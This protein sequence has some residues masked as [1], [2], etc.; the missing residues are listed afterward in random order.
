MLLWC[1]CPDP[2]AAL[3]VHPQ[4]H[5]T[6]A[7]LAP[8]CTPAPSS[9]SLLLLPRSSELTCTNPAEPV[10]VYA[11]ADHGVLT[12]PIVAPATKLVTVGVCE[13]SVTK[14]APQDIT[15]TAVLKGSNQVV[16]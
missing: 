14:V 11:G 12:L 15:D 10:P 9:P 2:G 1:A 16:W 8:V 6:D 7:A 3:A 13:W 4:H 5:N